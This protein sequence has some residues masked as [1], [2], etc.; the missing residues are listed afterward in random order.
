M[1]SRN[2]EEKYIVAISNPRSGRNKRGGFDKFTKAIVKFPAIE[3]IVTDSENGLIAALDTCKYKQCRVLVVNGGDGTLLHILTYLKQQSNSNFNPY[4]VL[5]RAGTTSMAYGD[6]GCRGKLENVLAKLQVFAAH[7]ESSLNKVERSVLKMSLPQENQVLCGMFFGA[8]AIYNGILYCRQT[9]HT[10]GIRGEVGPSMAMIRYLFDWLTTNR[11]TTSTNAKICFEG[12]VTLEDEFT[13]ITATTL[14]R[15]LMG[16]YPF[17]SNGHN[18]AGIP[19]TII[20]KNAP[21]PARAFIKIL[22]GK[23]PNIEFGQ[24]CYI[25]MHSSRIVFEVNDGFTLDGELFGSA[26]KTS[27]V[28]LESAGKVTFLTT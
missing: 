14:H 19:I 20:K 2:I 8:G 21:N 15:L 6:V 25:S 10:K 24:E 17:W 18:K 3:H 5:L 16:V 27:K 9:L 12:G 23:Q 11:M 26:N 1:N 7:T 13:I 22:L 28:I 4:L